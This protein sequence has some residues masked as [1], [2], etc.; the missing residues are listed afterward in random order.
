MKLQEFLQSYDLHDSGVNDVHYSPDQR[1]VVIDLVLRNW[2]Q[3]SYREGEPDSISGK[4]IFTGV[5]RYEIETEMPECAFDEDEILLAKLL[6]SQDEQKEVLR[7]TLL[8][9]LFPE[10]KEVIKVIWIEAEDV[11]WE[12]SGPC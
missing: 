9:I 8:A 6:P 1:K 5:S 2:R 3:L 12:V 4:L 11:V 10:R 7:I